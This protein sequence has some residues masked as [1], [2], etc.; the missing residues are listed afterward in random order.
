[1]N[2]AESLIETALA[3]GVDVCF[4]NPGTTEMPIVQALD[5]VPGP[6]RNWEWRHLDARLQPR[7]HAPL[8]AGSGK[9]RGSIALTTGSAT[10]PT[11][12]R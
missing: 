9:N 1:M 4:A 7:G 11:T 3:C 10:W 8:P 5:D 6:M 12:T 2:G